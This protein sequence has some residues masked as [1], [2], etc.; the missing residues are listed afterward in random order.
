MTV[1]L[2]KTNSENPDFVALVAQLDAYLK[3]TDGDEHDF[4][5][6]FNG[7]EQLNHVVV[8]YCDGQAIACGAIK[9]KQGYGME[10]KRM[11]THPNYRGKGTSHKVPL[12]SLS[13]KLLAPASS[14]PPF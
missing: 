1:T 12:P 7:I 8:A 9:P 5:N 13:G 10:V 2:N 3:T 6:Q 4:Y 11:F 14:A